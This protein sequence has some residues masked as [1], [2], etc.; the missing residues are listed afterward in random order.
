MTLTLLGDFNLTFTEYFDHHMLKE[1]LEE[2]EVIRRTIEEERDNIKNV[3]SEI[4]SKV[5]DIVYITGSGTSYHAGL[6]AQYAL[7]S[8]TNLASSTIPASEF[9]RWVPPSISRRSLVVAISQ[10]GESSDIIDA[11]KYAVKRKMRVLAV[12]NTPGS[13]L[14]NLADYVII[15]RSG[16]EIAVPATKT[17]VAQ[18]TAVLMFAIELAAFKESETDISILREKFFKVP[19]LVEEIL[20][21]YRENIRETATKYKDKNLIFALGSGPNYATAL[22]TALK[23]KETCMVF[24]EGFATREFLH[25]PIRLVDERTLMILIS[26]MEEVNDY[27]ELSRSFRSFGAKVISV[28]EKTENSDAFLK[29]FDD[30]FFVPYG[31]PKIFSPIIFIVPLQLFTYYVAIFKG[32]NP[33]KPEK[34]VKV[35]K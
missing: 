22:E 12:T 17:Y 28:L 7:S 5:F 16:K 21:F 8:L 31:L 14:A 13:S 15:P 30:V 26:P 1:V 20:K 18:L 27:I 35:V 34:L 2:P 10:S 29:F 32:L 33:D 4:A 24:A 19:L 23:L 25:G 11:V 6:V 3:A 9:Q